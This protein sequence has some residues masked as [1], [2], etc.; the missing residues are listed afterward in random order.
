M[1]ESEC[2]ILPRYGETDLFA[3]SSKK[4]KAAAA[5]PPTPDADAAP[6]AN[7]VHPF[8]NWTLE[9]LKP[10]DSFIQTQPPTTTSTASP[11]ARYLAVSAWSPPPHPLRLRGHIIYLTFSTLEGEIFHITGATSGFW[12]SKSGLHTFDPSPRYPAPP[13]VQSTPYHSLFDLFSALSPIFAKGLVSLLEQQNPNV[14]L[15]NLYATLPV[16]HAAPAA[17]WLVAAPVHHSDPF[18]TQLAYLLTTTTKAELLP[19]ARDWNDELVQFKELPSTTLA[20]KLYRERL[21]SRVQSEFVSAATQGA[22]AIERGD[23]AALNP[24][25][26]EESHTYIH[27]NMLYTRADDAVGGFSHVGGNAASR[28]AA[29][30]DLRGVGSLEKLDIDGLHTMATLLVDI[31]G[32]RWVVQSIIPGLLSNSSTQ[33]LEAEEAKQSPDKSDEENAAIAADKPF[34]SIE[35]LNKDDYPPQSV[36]RIVYGSVNPELPDEKVRSSKFFG[37][38]AQQI[39]KGLHLAEHTVSDAEG[40]KTSLWTSTDCHGIAGQDGRSYLLDCCMFSFRSV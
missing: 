32:K 23:I 2:L 34:P 36:F 11:C 10:F 15:T 22:I 38:L 39:A 31:G 9:S 18:R 24:N 27:N 1:P 16:T 28:V 14:A 7:T 21:L 13:G 6:D 4:S 20:D 3:E 29:S 33:S 35:T 26:S 30:K 19:A 5:A 25:E 8:T 37:S 12:V 17:S 40:A